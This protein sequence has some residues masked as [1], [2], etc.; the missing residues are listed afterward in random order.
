MESVRN[1]IS[2]LR[3]LPKE[4]FP[5]PI[6]KENGIWSLICREME[7]GAVIAID[8]VVHARAAEGD[9]RRE[10]PDSRAASQPAG[11]P[12]AA[13]RVADAHRRQHEDDEGNGGPVHEP[14]EAV[15][16]DRLLDVDRGQPGV[17]VHAQLDLDESATSEHAEVA[18]LLDM[19]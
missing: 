18:C 10:G 14:A 11:N 17:H 4:D 3:V 19:P 1:Y 16:A 9:S 5:N 6:L 13:E 15:A 8:R 2:E 7:V 12:L